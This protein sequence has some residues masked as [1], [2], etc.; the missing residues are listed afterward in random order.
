MIYKHLLIFYEW[1]NVRIECIIFDF[2]Q[3]H[4]EHFPRQSDRTGTCNW[5][6]TVRSQ[7]NTV[8]RVD[9]TISTTVTK[10]VRKKNPKNKIISRLGFK[11]LTAALASGQRPWDRPT[12]SVCHAS[13]TRLYGNLAGI[14]RT[15]R[16]STRRFTLAHNDIARTRTRAIHVARADS[17]MT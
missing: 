13:D 10:E 6:S 14:N 12:S 8:R 7:V 2:R 9:Y 16:V 11:R 1:N 4:N 3:I 15:E 17:L 5:K